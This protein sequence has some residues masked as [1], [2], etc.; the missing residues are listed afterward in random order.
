MATRMEV[1]RTIYGLSRRELGK[2]VH[3]SESCIFE[4]EKGLIKKP[5]IE[6]L[7]AF[8]EE[9]NIK[10]YKKVLEIITPDYY[11]ISPD[12]LHKIALVGG[13]GVDHAVAA[14]NK[15]RMVEG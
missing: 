10:N 2:R 9:L 13:L 14:Q 4:Y 1:M 15:S 3:L 12:V 6:I 5:N 7:K 11:I 8:A